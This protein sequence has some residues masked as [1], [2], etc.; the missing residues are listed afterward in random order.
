MPLHLLSK[1]SWNVYAPDNIARVKRDE[2]AAA[3]AEEEEDRRKDEYDA[4][5]RL[6]ILR[7]ETPPERPLAL[8]SEENVRRKGRDEGRGEGRDRKR[9]R[10]AGEDDTERDLRAAREDLES[11]RK[12]PTREVKKRKRSDAP[13]TDHKGH[14]NLF[15][16]DPRDQLKSEKNAEVEAEKARKQR[17]LED[18]YTM[19]LDNAAGRDGFKDKPWYASTSSKVKDA[20]ADAAIPGQSLTAYGEDKN[21]WGR[22]DPRRKDR[23]RARMSAGDPLAFMSKAQVQLKQAE[24]DRKRWAEDRKLEMEGLGKEPEKRQHRERRGRKEKQRRC[25]QHRD[26][27]DTLEG[28]SLDA[29]VEPLVARNGS[30]YEQPEREREQ[31]QSHRRNRDRSRDKRPRHHTSRHD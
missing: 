11:R 28:F 18:Q 10:V 20:Q 17:E 4:E 22:P 15:P 7:G 27:D 14:I 16:I 2:A 3:A 26:A 25:E 29:P 5:R 21:V 23:E 9:R 13:I 24:I 6:A 30:R 1:K 31:K 12:P 8:E 19:R